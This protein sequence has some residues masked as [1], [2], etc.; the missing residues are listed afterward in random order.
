M[1]LQYGIELQNMRPKFCHDPDHMYGHFMKPINITI[2]AGANI[3]EQTT[4]N[5]YIENRM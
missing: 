3:T 1:I 4:K 2:V 5:Q